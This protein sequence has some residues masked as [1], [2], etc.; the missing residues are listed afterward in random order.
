MNEIRWYLPQPLFETEIINRCP[1]ITEIG[2]CP[3]APADDPTSSNLVHI[4]EPDDFQA[5]SAPSFLRGKFAPQTATGV[6]MADGALG[7][8]NTPAAVTHPR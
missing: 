7:H 5:F 1:K 6:R 4:P 8:H 3:K 2:V